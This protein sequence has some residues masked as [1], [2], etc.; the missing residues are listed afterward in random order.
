MFGYVE[1]IMISFLGKAGDVFQLIDNSAERILLPVLKKVPEGQ[2]TPQK[3][4]LN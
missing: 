2:W 1:M 4:E 3:A